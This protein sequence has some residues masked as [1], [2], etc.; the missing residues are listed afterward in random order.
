MLNPTASGDPSEYVTLSPPMMATPA[1]TTYNPIN[2]NANWNDLTGST[3]VTV[4]VDPAST[5]GVNGFL[6]ATSSTVATAGDVLAI[7]WAAQAE[8]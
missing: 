3:D 4:S 5:A 7:H 1:I 8:L 6:L 2:A